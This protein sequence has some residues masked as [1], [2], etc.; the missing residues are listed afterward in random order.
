MGLF[1]RL[2]TLALVLSFGITPLGL[3]PANAGQNWSSGFYVGWVFFS[4]RIDTNFSWGGQ[5]QGLQGFVI[6]KY[7]GKGQLMV[8]IDSQ[9]VGG[10]SIV[11][12]TSIALTDYGKISLPNGTCT[13]SSSIL[14]QTNSVH[15]RGAGSAMGDS[16][17]VP[18]NLV[19]G[20]WYKSTNGASFGELKGC[21][22]AGSKNLA[23]MKIA[24]HRTTGEIQAMQFQV[25][26]NYNTASSIGGT[27]TIP[28]WV[29]TTPIP[30]GAGQGVRSLPSCDWRVF[31]SSQPN[32]QKGWK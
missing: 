25:S 16:F 18:I 13:F 26:D 10:V 20:I 30:N 2:L 15:L 29:T 6:E 9:G 21:D 23:S 11:L 3:K 17:Q 31:K 19:S 24:M 27:C 5:G 8:K 4:A 14:A 28:G 32:Q 1:S 7:D 12:P 22:Q